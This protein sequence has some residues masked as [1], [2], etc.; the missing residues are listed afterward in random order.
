MQQQIDS[1]RVILCAVES[2]ISVTSVCVVYQCFKTHKNKN[3]LDFFRSQARDK[4]KEEW[5][6]LNSLDHVSLK[7]SEKVDEWKQSLRNK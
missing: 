6:E 4:N 2:M 1:Y 3:K 5:C 7:Y